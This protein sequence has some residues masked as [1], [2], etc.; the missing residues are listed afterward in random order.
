MVYPVVIFGPV[1]DVER[2]VDHGIEV[3]VEVLVWVDRDL[4]FLVVGQAVRAFAEAEEGVMDDA[5]GAP[6]VVGD[7]H[8]DQDTTRDGRERM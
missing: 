3:V 1:E 2:L 8:V 5:P 4:K 6:V 7:F